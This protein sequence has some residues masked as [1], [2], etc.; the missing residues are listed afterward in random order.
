MIKYKYTCKLLS[1]LIITSVTATEGFHESLDYIPGSKF[2]GIAAGQLYEKM[3]VSAIDLFHNGK[4]RFGNAYP[5]IEGQRALPVAFSWYFEKGL[6]LTEPPIYL[7]HNLKDDDFREISRRTQLKQARVGYFTLSGKYA[8]IDQDFSLRSAYDRSLRR[9]KDENM[10]GYF[11]LPAGSEWSFEVEDDTEKYAED[12]RG[13]LVGKKR[14]GRS[15]SA[16]YGLVEIDFDGISKNEDISVSLQ[17][18]ANVLY[19]ESNLCFNDEFGRNTLR[20]TA[21]QLG[22]PEGE[23]DWDKSQTRHR[24]YQ[25]WNRKRHNR[26]ADRMIFEKGSVFVVKGSDSNT[27]HAGEYCVGSHLAEGFGKILINPDFL[28]SDSVQLNLQF[29]GA[30]IDAIPSE[31]PS[32][33]SEDQLLL[34]FLAKS[35]NKQEGTIELD[36][37][38]NAFMKAN[39]DSFS[40]VSASQWG[41]I[42][43]Y[44]RQSGTWEELNAYLFHE[45]FGALHRGQSEPVWREHNRRG[46]LLQEIERLPNRINRITFVIKLAAE[47]A[48]RKN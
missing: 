15:R 6:G 47:M 8:R 40:G 32:A 41:T 10:F 29:S 20:P 26:D 25:T 35:S 17:R 44:A 11:S 31:L 36:R 1:D 46:K 27:H 16:E 7:H 13:S 39:K 24:L 34:D 48:K 42:R 45:E 12:V 43:S 30:K 37:L 21:A 22:F 9:A 28:L 19:A 3:G 33:T 14:I 18:E 5:L 2:L 4:V 23:I 38:V